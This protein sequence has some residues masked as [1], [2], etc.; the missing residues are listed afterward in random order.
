[1]AGILKETAGV[2]YN[3][4]ESSNPVTFEAYGHTWDTFSKST[5]CVWC[6]NP[7][8]N[9]KKPNKGLSSWAKTKEHIIPRSKK[10]PDNTRRVTAAHYVCNVKR[11]VST[12]WVPF[13][14]GIIAMPYE[15][16]VWVNKVRDTYKRDFP[17]NS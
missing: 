16:Q 1:M 12:D 3:C 17:V 10:T 7:F 6:G 8:M 5:L 9:G 11:R 13:N 14:A 15:Q 2:Y 4:L